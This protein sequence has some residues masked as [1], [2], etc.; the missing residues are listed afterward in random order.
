MSLWSPCHVKQKQIS[1]SRH[2][3]HDV[4]ISNLHGS[5]DQHASQQLWLHSAFPSELTLRWP[6]TMCHVASSRAQAMGT[7]QMNSWLRGG[8]ILFHLVCLSVFWQGSRLGSFWNYL[9]KR[10]I[11]VDFCTCL[12]VPWN[13]WLCSWLKLPTT[14]K[15]HAFQTGRQAKAPRLI[16]SSYPWSG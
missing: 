7:R 15:V 5:L 11:P 3:Q 8:N 12:Q 2:W 9:A 16:T 13:I 4:Q 10:W 6:K 14:G 1:V